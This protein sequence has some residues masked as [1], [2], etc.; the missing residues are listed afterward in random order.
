MY[1][2]RLLYLGSLATILLIPNVRTGVQA[3]PADFQQLD[4]IIKVS[5]ATKIY[6]NAGIS[7][8]SGIVS[9]KFSLIYLFR[10][11]LQRTGK[12]QIW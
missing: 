8:I 6:L 7:G 2:Q 5:D 3:P 9:V 10:L 1:G 12:L 4:G 11:L